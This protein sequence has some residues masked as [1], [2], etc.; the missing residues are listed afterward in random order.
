[1]P[2]YQIALPVPKRQTYMYTSDQCLH[3]GVRVQVP[4]AGRSLI[5][6][7]M[8][9]AS[10]TEHRDITLKNVDRVL[11]T[12]PL[13]TPLMLSLCQWLS[14]YYQHPI[15]DVLFTCLPAALRKDNPS[16]PGPVEV[17]SLAVD[18]DTARQQTARAPKQRTL[19]E[20]LSQGGRRV[21]DVRD[22]LTSAIKRAMLDK[23]IIKVESQPYTPEQDWQANLRL[24]EKPHANAEQALAISAITS[25]LGRFGVFLL[26]GVTGSGKTEV[27]LQAIEEVLLQGQQ[28]LVLVPEIGLTPQTVLRFSQ[29]F[30]SRIG[31]LHSGLSDNER[32]RVWQQSR[33]GEIGLIIGTR[34][35]IFTPMQTPGLIIVDEEHDLS[36]KQQDGLRYHARDYAAKRAKQENIPL[37]LGS[38]TP[39]L[40]TLQNALS[41]RYQHLILSHRAGNA[42]PPTQHLMDI[43]EQPLRVGI[44]AGMTQRIRQH[45]ERGNQVLLFINRRGYAPAYVC[46]QCGHVESCRRCDKPYTVHRQLNKLQ[47][48]H[49]ASARPI[50]KTCNQCHQDAMFGVGVGTEQLEQGLNTLFP[51]RKVLRLDSDTVKGKGKLSSQLDKVNQPEYQLLVGTQILSKGHHFP[52]VTLVVVLDADGALFSGDF[53]ASEHLAQLVTQLAGRAGRAEQPGEM[54]LQ[55]H[56]P[57]HPL[58]QDLT[59]N[60]YQHFA[61]YALL[62]RKHAHLPPFTYQAL[63]RAEATHASLPHAFL[64]RCR[65]MLNEMLQSSA[66]SLQ[67]IGPLPSLMEKRQGKYRMQLL[68]Q[69]SQR[70]TLHR[71]LSPLLLQLENVPEAR[72]VR[73]SVDVDPQDFT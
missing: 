20:M 18:I 25:Q 9:Q 3:D 50:P 32:L 65:E 35:A 56:N 42:R 29:R 5:G 41:N 2:V 1:M 34:S 16:E 10:D 40:E 68:L 24:G 43:R 62:E 61:R 36:Y 71:L 33:D 37:V 60:G 39:S 46:H 51:E 52:R 47:C 31:V 53:R 49:C 73:W 8:G 17:V 13:F 66:A 14:Q 12:R 57:G 58:L 7:V 63:L 22:L 67:I 23:A 21:Q 6:I 19:V 69:S 26:E 72:K 15:G 38:A 4:F 44:A 59:N 27:Y 48:H 30:G 28:V 70:S 11:D 64:S 55:T 54:W 45:L